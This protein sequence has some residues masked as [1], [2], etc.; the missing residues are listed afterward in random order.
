MV[1]APLLCLSFYSHAGAIYGVSNAATNCSGSPHGLWTNNSIGGG[2][3]SN[4]FS[5]DGSIAFDDSDGN[6]D[7]WTA[8]LI[9]TAVNPQAVS[10]DVNIVFKNFSEDRAG[11][12][13]EGGRANNSW[14][15]SAGITNPLEDD[16]DFFEEV[17]GL[18]SI[19]GTDYVIDGFAGGYAFQFGMGANAKSANVFGGSAWVLRDTGGRHWDLNLTFGPNITSVPAP[20]MLALLGIGLMGLGWQRKRSA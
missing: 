2:A 17:D 13:Q 19:G 14:T 5:I 3:C 4:N 16:V 18:I 15:D 6:T 8:T 9:A 12:K 20:A 1:F 7:N 11:Y 10:A